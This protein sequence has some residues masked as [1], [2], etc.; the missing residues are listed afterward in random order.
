MG[1]FILLN[2]GYKKIQFIHKILTIAMI[3][4]LATPLFAED[5]KPAPSQKIAPAS[6]TVKSPVYNPPKGAIIA[7]AYIDEEKKMPVYTEI[8]TAFYKNGKLHTS[9][10]DYFDLSGNKI[11]ELNSD[12]SKSLMMPTYIFRDLRTGAEE[13]LRWEDGKYWI[14]RQTKGKPEE[15]KL[16]DSVENT[17][18]CQG[19][20]Y[21]LLANLDRLQKNPIK[22][23]LIFPSKLDYYS[24]R[25]RL[26]DTTENVLKLRLEF[27][28]WIIRLFTPYLDITYDKKNRKIVQYFG[29]SNISNDKGEIQN[30]YIFYE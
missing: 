21:Y 8:H 7:K 14:F 18:S 11:A 12:Y 30:V 16:L 2:L 22:M 1:A 4:G 24:F 29:P 27:D 23:K 6:V 28:S 19:W 5:N 15:V 13:G 3:I 20:H 9:N 26:L 25:I 10:N 17:F